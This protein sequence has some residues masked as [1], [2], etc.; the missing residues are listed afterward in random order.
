MKSGQANGAKKP[1]QDSDGFTM[2]PKT[3]PWKAK[4]THVAHKGNTTNTGNSFT[5]LTQKENFDEQ[6]GRLVAHM[7]NGAQA[8]DLG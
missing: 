5:T 7:G 6:E 2:V 3:S 1:Q 4:Q 8:T